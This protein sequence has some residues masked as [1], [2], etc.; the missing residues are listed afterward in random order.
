MDEPLRVLLAVICLIAGLATAGYAGY[1]QYGVLPVERTFAKD[2]AR[3]A[4]F[5]AGVA[6]FVA[7][8]LLLP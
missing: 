1:L 2:S 6:L 5:L 4:I 8:S 3:P 7:G